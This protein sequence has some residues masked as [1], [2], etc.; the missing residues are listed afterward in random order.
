MFSE[1]I[2]REHADRHVYAEA[3]NRGH[4]VL[5]LQAATLDDAE[6]AADIIDDFND[7]HRR[8]RNH[9][10]RQ[11]LGEALQTSVGAQ[12]LAPEQHGIRSAKTRWCLRAPSR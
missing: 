5:T 12:Q 4:T 2:G 6:R 8:P 7:R 11:R 3:L 10:A 9:V 1:L